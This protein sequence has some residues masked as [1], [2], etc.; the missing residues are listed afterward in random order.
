MGHGHVAGVLGP[1]GVGKTRLL[2]E[3]A[4][5]LESM[6]AQEVDAGPEVV[7]SHCFPGEGVPACWLWTQVL[8]R[9]SATRPDAFRE[10]TRPYD[11]LLGPLLTERPAARTGG[12]EL[13]LLRVPG[14][15][16]RP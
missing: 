6:A 11:A 14:P 13:V 16:P 9:L 3:L 10:A 1:P 15:L 12:P 7:W 5:R 2:L 4:A 8:R